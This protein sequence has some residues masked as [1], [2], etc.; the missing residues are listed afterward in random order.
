MIIR[1]KK[2]PAAFMTAGR[3]L[4]SLVR[5]DLLQPGEAR[6]GVAQRPLRLALDQGQ[7]VFDE[8]VLDA[9]PVR[10]DPQARKARWMS[11]CTI[12]NKT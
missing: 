9:V 8:R 5:Q 12:C 7:G 1:D 4:L 10:R 6:Q 11:S 2:R 3:F